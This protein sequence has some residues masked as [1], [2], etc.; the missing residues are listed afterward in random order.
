LEKKEQMLVSVDVSKDVLAGYWRDINKAR[1]YENS[2]EGI[3]KLVLDIAE[4]KP[5]LVVLECTGGYEQALAE[6]LWLHSIP[7]TK[8]NPGRVRHFCLAKGYLAKTD[9][10]D[11]KAIYEFGLA[12]ELT[13]QKPPSPG[14]KAVKQLFLRRKQLKDMI[15]MEKNHLRA[16]CTDTVVQSSIRKIL[17]SLQKEV[18]ALDKKIAKDL[19]TVP[20]IKS[21]LAV[22]EKEKG[23]GP[24]VLAALLVLLP[25][26][27]T[28]NRRTIASLA[29]VAPFNHDS[30]LA[31]GK[32]CIKGGRCN[33]RSILYMATLAAIR[34]NGTIK[35][36]YLRLVQRGKPK[37]VAVTACIRKFLIH[38]NSLARE[39]LLSDSLN[40][41]Q[42]S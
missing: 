10:I 18:A 11:A 13:P 7:L 41:W 15:V 25:E 14:L 22:L 40:A 19:R 16:P 3:A 34:T 21:K 36:F 27:G 17:Q 1:M 31:E 5:S 35:G 12:M 26:L 20:E 2:T 4:V 8:V 6:A 30:G 32:R 38:L 23:V 28:L 42:G 9:P 37:M 39:A 33:L 29:G 24:T